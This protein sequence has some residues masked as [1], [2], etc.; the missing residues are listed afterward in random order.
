MVVRS[1]PDIQEHVILEHGSERNAPILSDDRERVP[2][3]IQPFERHAHFSL[4]PTH[5][6]FLRNSA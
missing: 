5:R 4:M 2:L 6:E 3:G 1:S